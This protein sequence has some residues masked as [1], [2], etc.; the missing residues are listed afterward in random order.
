MK[1]SIDKNLP[2]PIKKQL[3]QQIRGMIDSGGLL[4]GQSLP[5]CSDLSAI[6]SVNRN[7]V[8][9][10]YSEL[11]AQDVLTC[12]RGAGTM[13]NPVY[14]PRPVKE[15]ALMMERLFQRAKKLGFSNEELTDQFFFALAMQ[16]AVKKKQVL[17]AWCN[18]VTLEEV[19]TKLEATLGVKT[20]RFLLEKGAQHA[21]SISPHLSD[22]DLVVSSITHVEAILPHA[23][24]AG[25]EVTGIIL[26]PVAQ[27]LNHMIGLPKGT[28]VGFICVNDAA[29][30]STCKSVHLSNQVTLHT[31]W[32][33][34]DDAP[35]LDRIFSRCDIIFATH[36]VY[37][38]I[39]NLAG[40]DQTLVK[41]DV[42]ITDSSIDLIRER[43]TQGGQKESFHG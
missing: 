15:L 27:I 37:D 13:V 1:F 24:K 22:V 17:L 8:A 11:S 12:N 35:G 3:K 42:S 28:T 26:T 25:V 34:A 38:R 4:P 31:I 20:R 29:A 10:V 6:L 2:L 7:T 18:E 33:G 9:S 16:S 19:A 32:A 41:V 40:K 14:R 5:S 30:E 21:E 36:H 39:K 43:L 23:R